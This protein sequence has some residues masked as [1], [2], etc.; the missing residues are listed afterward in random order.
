MAT[1]PTDNTK[2]KL[3]PEFYSFNIDES[4]RQPASKFLLRCMKYIPKNRDNVFTYI[5]LVNFM[6]EAK[7]DEFYYRGGAFL[8]DCN[9]ER[10]WG[11]SKSK[12]HKARIENFN[13]YYEFV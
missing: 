1:H 13:N 8:K 7:Y 5:K 6:K 3:T 9:I 2:I 10:Y 12:R 4:S 11:Y